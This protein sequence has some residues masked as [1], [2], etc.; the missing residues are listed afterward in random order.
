MIFAELDVICCESLICFGTNKNL[1][2]FFILVTV[3][4]TFIVSPH[5]V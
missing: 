1:Q 2:F 5:F 3:A 4:F